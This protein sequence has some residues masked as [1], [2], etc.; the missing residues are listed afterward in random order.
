MRTAS[1][2]SPKIRSQ[3]RSAS[4]LRSRLSVCGVAV[5]DHIEKI[6][7]TR[8]MC[9]F[10]GS[11]YTSQTRTSTRERKCCVPL[12]SVSL[13]C[14]A[15]CPSQTLPNVLV[16]SL[17]KLLRQLWSDHPQTEVRT[18]RTTANEQKPSCLDDCHSGCLR[19]LHAPW[20][21]LRAVSRRTP[22]CRLGRPALAGP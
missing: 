18:G 13:V 14:G 1:F 8:P 3:I 6:R 11:E 16:V 10:V 9:G 12:C 19:E 17:R 22:V 4:K 15:N 21:W 2:R 20:I 5:V 7:R